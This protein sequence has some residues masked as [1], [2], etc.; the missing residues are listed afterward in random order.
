MGL[1]FLGDGPR[2]PSTPN[3]IIDSHRK[4]QGFKTTD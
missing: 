4:Y 1:N 3:R 2:D